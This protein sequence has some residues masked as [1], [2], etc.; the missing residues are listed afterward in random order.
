[1]PS[2]FHYDYPLPAVA[3]DMVIL[4]ISR[5]AELSCLLV[6]RGEPPFEGSWALPGGFLDVGG[7]YRAGTEQGEDLHNA[8]ARELQEETGLSV[9][10]HQIFLEQLYTFGAAGRDPRGR[11]ITVAYYAL[12]SV[13]FAPLLR[14]GDDA[15]EVMWHP[16]V[17]AER[18]Q[19]LA[20]AFD[21][22]EIIRVALER[23][24]GKIDYDPRLVRALLPDE[25]TQSE[26]RRVH[27]TIKGARYDK[28]NFSKRF[29]RMLEDGR[30]EATDEKRALRGAGRPP[31]LYRFVE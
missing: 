3:V 28:S 24:R 26:F 5:R 19:E 30:F 23:V 11:V 15:R 20:L 9:D 18:S 29:R 13:E 10:R 27:E 12:L 1:M 31:K 16:V 21:H 8:A 25:F 6:R 7:G 22:R 4:T 2:N 14:A 17:E